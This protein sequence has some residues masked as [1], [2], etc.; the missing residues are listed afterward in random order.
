MPPAVQTST[1]ISGSSA[2]N[3]Y[4]RAIKALGTGNWTEFGTEMQQLG[5]DLGQN[6]GGMT[7]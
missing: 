6:S 4:N 3:H 1:S 7:H 2:A 5:Q